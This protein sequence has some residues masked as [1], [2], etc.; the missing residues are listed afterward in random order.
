MLSFLGERKW[1]T[2]GCEA[3]ANV[4]SEQPKIAVYVFKTTPASEPQTAVD[5]YRLGIQ[6][7][8]NPAI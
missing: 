4:P 3:N 6:Q 2:T 1:G 7:S 5:E 8:K